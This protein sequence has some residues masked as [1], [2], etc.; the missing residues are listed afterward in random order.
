[1]RWP[2]HQVDAPGGRT[3]SLCSHLTFRESGERFERIFEK[4]PSDSERE[5]TR[6]GA[7]KA[8]RRERGRS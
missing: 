7:L 6:K 3:H 2:C 8:W 5:R 1:M 4:R